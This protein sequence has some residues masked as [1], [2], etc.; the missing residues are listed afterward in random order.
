M[1]FYLF[2]EVTFYS[3]FQKQNMLISEKS[4]NERT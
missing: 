2:K 1:T 4:E 3:L